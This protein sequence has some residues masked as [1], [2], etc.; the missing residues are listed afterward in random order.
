[1][2]GKKDSC[3]LSNEEIRDKCKK[4]TDLLLLWDGS[5]AV[6]RKNNP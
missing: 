3:I 5:F 4:Y 1:V 6:A 2:S